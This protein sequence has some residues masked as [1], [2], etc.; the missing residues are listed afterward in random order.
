LLGV[1]V[2]DEAIGL[3]AS[4]LTC[5]S[6]SLD[7]AAA[8]GIGTVAKSF[9]FAIKDLSPF[10]EFKAKV[11]EVLRKITAKIVVNRT[12]NTLVC[13]PNMDSAD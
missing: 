6:L 5:T 4:T 2:S 12:M 13:V 10:E 3:G 9:L 8:D 7:L 1:A 11:N